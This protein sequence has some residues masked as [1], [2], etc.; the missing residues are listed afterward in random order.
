MPADPTLTPCTWLPLVTKGETLPTVDPAPTHVPPTAT[1]TPAAPQTPAAT[2]SPTNTPSPTPTTTETPIPTGQPS[3]EACVVHVHDD[4]ATD[5]DSGND[6]YGDYVNQAVVDGMVQRGLQVLTGESSWAAIWGRLF[7]QVQTTGY[8]TGEKILIKVNLN[9]STRNGGCLGTDNAID[10]LPQPVKALI[11]GLVAAGVSQDDIWIYDATKDGRIIPNRFRLPIASTY[12]AVQ[13]WGRGECS[14]VNPVSHGGHASLTVQFAKPQLTDRQ[15]A[16][17]LHQATYLINMPILKR[18]GI[19]PVTL[20][21]KNHF[22]S[23]NKIIR[24][25]HDNLH[26][27]IAPS[28]GLYD[29]FYSPLVD[30]YTNPNIRDKTILVLGDGLFG[31]G[32]ATLAPSPWTTFGNDYPNSLFF[33]ID[34]VAIDCVMA[35]FVKAEWSYGMEHAYD[36]LFCAE[37]HGLGTCEGSR[38]NPGGDPRGSGYEDIDYRAETL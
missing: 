29:P 15:L 22:G 27:F 14:T 37:E 34:P 24:G 28:E 10:A 1:D 3:G 13:F 4:D 8:Q 30:I 20:G 2:L 23:L 31:A 16:D 35:D 11:G 18:H 33:A 6:Y 25:G 12:P 9:N 36:Y 32:G 26:D 7:S 5:W 21:F 17:L 19:S 38:D